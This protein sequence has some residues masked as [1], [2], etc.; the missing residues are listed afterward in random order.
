MKSSDLTVVI[1]TLNRSDLLAR[2]L[3]HLADNHWKSPIILADSSDGE[4]LINNK[5]IVGGY[6]GV[7]LIHHVC[8]TS[9]TP[10]SLKL[11]GAVSLVKSEYVVICADDDIIVPAIVIQSADFLS[12]NPGYSLC[13]GV[14]LSYLHQVAADGSAKVVIVS[15]NISDSLEQGTASGR[16]MAQYH[17][18]AATF[19]GV[20]R[21]ESLSNI[22]TRTCQYLPGGSDNGNFQEFIEASLTVIQGKVKRLPYLYCVRRGAPPTV[23]FE[24]SLLGR[25]FSAYLDALRVCVVKELMVHET[26]SKEDALQFFDA[27]FMQFISKG[28]GVLPLPD[29]FKEYHHKP[30][31]TRPLPQRFVDMVMRDAGSDFVEIHRVLQNELLPVQANGQESL[32]NAIHPVLEAHR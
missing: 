11:A 31:G 32:S 14:Y 26:I 16:L 21:T 17:Q 18:Y 10:L 19:Y 5:S 3:K 22:L 4:H 9:I 1:I 28:L 25:N 6:G 2:L 8:Y 20:R 15:D 30:S 7:L 24:G 27:A 29:R 12:Q 13:H 23:G